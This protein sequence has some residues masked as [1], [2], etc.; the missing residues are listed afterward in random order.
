MK[1]LE[2]FSSILY[3][4]RMSSGKYLYGIIVYSDVSMV[5]HKKQYF[6]SQLINQAPYFASD[7]ILLNKILVSNIEAAGGPD[8]RAKSSFS[9]PTTKRILY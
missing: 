6:G 4:I 9:H 2:T 1:P 7:I 3:H 5:V 8:S